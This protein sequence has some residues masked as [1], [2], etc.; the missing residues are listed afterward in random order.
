MTAKP[1][2]PWIALAIGAAVL[3]L[4]GRESLTERAA[5]P[6]RR[7]LLDLPSIPQR[8]TP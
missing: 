8:G 7:P 3:V 6:D 2:L 1:I 4:A 5:P